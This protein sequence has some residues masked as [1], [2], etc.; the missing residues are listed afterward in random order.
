MAGIPKNKYELLPYST[1]ISTPNSL[2]YTHYRPSKREYIESSDV[3]DTG[4]SP[5]RPSKIRGRKPRE[6][7]DSSDIGYSSDVEDEEIKRVF[8]KSAVERRRTRT[9]AGG[10]KLE[11]IIISSSQISQEDSI[12]K[13]HRILS[14]AIMDGSDSVDFSYLPLSVMCILTVLGNADC[15]SF[16]VILA[17]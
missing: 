10:E 2:N 13:F 7:R 17:S 6:W 8:E 1:T 3:E 14:A 9:V 12:S 15:M 16:L 5:P 4:S 11:N